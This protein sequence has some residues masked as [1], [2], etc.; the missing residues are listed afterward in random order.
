MISLK[1]GVRIQGVRPEI[2]FAVVVVHGVWAA[3]KIEAVITSCVEGK[4][5]RASKHYIGCAFDVRLKNVPKPARGG[6]VHEV[7]ESLG[8][9]FD[10]IWE[11]EGELWEHLH[12][13]YD[14]KQP[15]AG[16]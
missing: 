1:P 16:D 11:G 4:H 12:V 5:K 8:E 3:N 6:F 10:V 2:L 9:D 13:E 14:P 15:L 7:E